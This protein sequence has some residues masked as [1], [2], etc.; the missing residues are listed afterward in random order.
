MT[1]AYL[2]YLDQAR[3]RLDEALSEA[4]RLE[5]AHTLA[6]VLVVA[7]CGVDYRLT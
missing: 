1:L 5:H 3:S 6:T 4:R 7:N 2:G